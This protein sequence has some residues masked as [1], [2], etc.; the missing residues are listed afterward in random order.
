MEEYVWVNGFVFNVEVVAVQFSGRPRTRGLQLR[1]ILLRLLPK[2]FLIPQL[3]VWWKRLRMILV[4][5][6]L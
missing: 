2:R 6:R 3:M 4:V 5:E 1:S